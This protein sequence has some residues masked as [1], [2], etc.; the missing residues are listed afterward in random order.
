MTFPDV[1]FV[2]FYRCIHTVTHQA[3]F[4]RSSN[5]LLYYNKKKQHSIILWEKTVHMNEFFLIQL[6]D[7]I[8]DIATQLIYTSQYIIY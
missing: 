6:K 1:V 3:A 2:F 4:R 5:N 7:C 8:H